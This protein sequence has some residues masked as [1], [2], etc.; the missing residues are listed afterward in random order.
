M[1]CLAHEQV[2]CMRAGSEKDAGLLHVRNAIAH[3]AR[4]SKN[5]PA[6]FGDVSLPDMA[7]AG[8]VGAAAQ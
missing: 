1:M 7:S 8:A 6:L 2:E 3:V 5:D 4:A